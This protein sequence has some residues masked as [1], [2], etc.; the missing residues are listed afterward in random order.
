MKVTQLISAIV[1]ASLTAGALAA[2]GSNSN[3]GT[4]S[5]SAAR[6]ASVAA[7]SATS[8]SRTS[9]APRSAAGSA[10]PAGLAAQGAV[11]RQCQITSHSKAEFGSCLNAHGFRVGPPPAGRTKFDACLKQAHNSADEATQLHQC[12]QLISTP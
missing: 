3:A 12:A 4:A 11:V 7:S 9:A 10:L 1:A 2:C 5:G 6:P 8:V